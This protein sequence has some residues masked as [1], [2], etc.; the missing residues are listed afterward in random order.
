MADH[1]HGHAHGHA[2]HHHRPEAYDR[3][4]ALA[5]ALNLAFVGVEGAAG[6]VANSLALVADAGHN[7]GDVLGLALAWGAAA[8]ARRRPTLRRTYGFGRSSVLA[9]LVNAMILLIAVGAIG[10]EAVTRLARP[11]PVEGDMMIWVAAA[12]VLLNGTTAMLFMAGRKH[13]LNLRGAFLH[14]AADAGVSL[15]VVVAGLLIGVTGWLWL[16]PATSLLIVAVIAVGTW[17][18]FRDS[19]D[20]AL[21]AVPDAIDREAVESWLRALPGVCEVHDLHIWAIST[22]ETALTA[23]LVRPGAPADDAFLARVST[24]LKARFAIGH[25]TL[26]IEIGDAEHPCH[27]APADVV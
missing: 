14:M 23:H 8:L 7:L 17:G 11:A 13:D 20:L 27:L 21:D 1:A 18:L 5:I 3:V 2:H 12:G 24:D 9:A 10:M 26:Q 16:D 15:G 6:F 19:L 4:F 22:T 25:A